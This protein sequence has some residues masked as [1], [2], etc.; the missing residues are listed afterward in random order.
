MGSM[1]LLVRSSGRVHVVNPTLWIRRVV[2][3]PFRYFRP[4]LVC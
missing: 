1:Q 3:V 4:L 2:V